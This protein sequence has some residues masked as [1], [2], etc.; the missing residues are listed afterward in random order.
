MYRQ[1]TSRHWGRCVYFRERHSVLIARM[2]ATRFC[3]PKSG[4]LSIVALAFFLLCFVSSCKDGGDE[5]DVSDVKVDLD[6]RRLDLDLAKMDTTQIAACLQALSKKYP[7]FL[8]FWLD[9]LMQFGVNGNYSDT[10]IGVHEHLH[11]FLTYKDFRGLFDTVAAHFP[12]TKSIDEP[13]KKGFQFY[14][15]YYPGRS[16]PK[17]VY[18]VSGLNNWSVVTVDTGIVGIGLDMYLGAGYP[19]YK[20]VGIPDYMTLQLRPEAV[21]VNVFRAIHEDRHPF[22]AENRTLLDMMIQRGKEQYFLSKV[23]PFVPDATRLGFADAQL[24]WCQKNE[25]LVYNFFVKSSMLYE[26]NWGKILRY[27]NDGPEATGMPKESPGNVGTWLGWQI[28]KAYM[29]KHPEMQMDALFAKSDAQAI[30]QEAQYKP[31]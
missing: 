8:D 3:T 11:Q 28:V 26:T 19:H 21:P 7:D 15:H 1:Q 4:L 6:T 30:L 29:A 5:P 18:F 27:V 25:A 24:E 14:K 16:V 12:D 17:I 9:D 2:P 23:I 20:S 22:I 10:A 31:R 13:V